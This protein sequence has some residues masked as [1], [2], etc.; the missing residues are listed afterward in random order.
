M[1]FAIGCVLRARNETT[2]SDYVCSEAARGLQLAQMDR[3]MPII[4]CVLT[5]ETV[6]SDRPRGIKGWE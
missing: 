5:C 2:H 6:A 1:T 3:G 4:F